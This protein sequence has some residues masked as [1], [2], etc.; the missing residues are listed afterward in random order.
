MNTNN[1]LKDNGTNTNDELKVLIAQ[2]VD[3]C[4]CSEPDK[5]NIIKELLYK[6]TMPILEDYPANIYFNAV[7]LIDSLEYMVNN[8]TE[9]QLLQS[10]IKLRSA[11]PEFADIPLFLNTEVFYKPLA[12]IGGC[13]VVMSDSTVFIVINED[14]PYN[15]QA[16]A[17]KLL[18]HS[19][20]KFNLLYTSDLDSNPTSA[21]QA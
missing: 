11:Y 9:E 19:T 15:L 21:K 8:C 18:H 4:L 14:I 20:E 2:L 3:E 16:L 6:H 1:E 13:R 5:F 12:D 10:R 17:L 7:Q